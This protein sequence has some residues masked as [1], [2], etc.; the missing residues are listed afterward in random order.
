[1]RRNLKNIFSYLVRK[2]KHVKTAVP[3]YVYSQH[4]EV[5]TILY[6]KYLLIH[7]NEQD[8]GIHSHIIYL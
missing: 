2:P 8:K 4:I 5:S 6:E 3:L 1:M 7:N